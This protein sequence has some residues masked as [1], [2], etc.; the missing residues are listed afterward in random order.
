MPTRRWFRR[1]SYLA[2]GAMCFLCAGCSRGTLPERRVPA[3]PVPESSGPELQDGISGEQVGRLANRHFKRPDDSGCY[4]E[5]RG[6]YYFV[7]PPYKRS[8][9]IERAG[10]YVHKV[11]GQMVPPQRA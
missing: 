5:E 4:I 3:E 2:E 7:S 9:D 6:E 11:S 8:R 1:V 10:V